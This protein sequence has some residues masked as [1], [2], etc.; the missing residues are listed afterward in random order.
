M[1][2]TEPVCDRCICAGSSV[3]EASWSEVASRRLER[4]SRLVAAVR[5]DTRLV[6]Q[7]P[8]GNLEVVHPR[9]LVVARLAHLMNR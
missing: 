5:G 6:L 1:C 4:G 2:P 3:S 8:R 7:M 9:P